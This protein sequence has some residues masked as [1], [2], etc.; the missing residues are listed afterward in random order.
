VI[1]AGAKR[2]AAKVQKEERFMKSLNAVLKAECTSRIVS[3]SGIADEVGDKNAPSLAE[4]RERAF[5]IHI[6]RGDLDDWLQVERELQE[7]TT[8]KKRGEQR[9][10]VRH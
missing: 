3:K 9:S 5:E 6:E 8:A 10:E 2:K 4:I 1:R 7:S